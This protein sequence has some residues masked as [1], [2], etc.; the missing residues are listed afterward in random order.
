MIEAASSRYG[1]IKEEAAREAVK[2]TRQ[3]AEAAPD[4]AR[5]AKRAEQAEA[6][7]ETLEQRQA[8]RSAKG[9]DAST[10]QVSP[11]EPDAMV[12]PQKDKKL[13]RASYKPSVLANAN[14]I[15]VAQE[16]DASSETAVVEALLEQATQHGEVSEAM[17]DAGYHTHEVIRQTQERSIELLCPEGRS[18]GDDWNKRSSKRYLKSQFQYDPETNTYTCPAGEFLREVGHYRGNDTNPGYTQ[19]GTLACET[20]DQRKACTSSKSGRRIKRYA[21]DHQKEALREKMTDPE[22]RQRYRKRQ[23]M[24][25]PV[26]SQLRLVQGLNRF[27]RRG[28]AQ[29]RCEFALHAMAYNLSRLLALVGPSCA[30]AHSW[31]VGQCHA[32]AHLWIAVFRW[33]PQ[34]RVGYIFP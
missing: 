29:V 30:H 17:F 27:R 22:V 26:F 7:L 1:L 20:C 8:A 13:I 12:Q 32:I 11:T 18:Q 31:L 16:V 33:R 21:D 9:K 28:L 24:V 34:W 19:Y 10:S 6:V 2:Q 14:R 4:H 5:L 25:E 23:G 15:I 3:D